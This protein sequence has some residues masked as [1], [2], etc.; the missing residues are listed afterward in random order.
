MRGRGMINLRN[1]CKA[2]V[3][4]ERHGT[5][6][7][8]NHGTGRDATG[9]DETREDQSLPSCSSANKIN[10]HKNMSPTSNRLYSTS[11]LKTNA[12]GG[13]PI[14]R[15]GRFDRFLTKNKKHN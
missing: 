5:P 4:A 1:E 8:E 2:T 12:P 6:E 15:D 3:W 7:E 9:Q 13:P 11:F 14:V 10:N